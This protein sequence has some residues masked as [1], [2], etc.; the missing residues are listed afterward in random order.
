MLVEL[1]VAV[2][3]ASSREEPSLEALREIREAIA[4]NVD[5]RIGTRTPVPGDKGVAQSLLVEPLGIAGVM[6][7]VRIVALWL[8]RDRRRRIEIRGE[9]REDGSISYSF[10]GE[11]VS[12]DLL[13]SAISK[14]LGPS[15]EST[16]E[17][18]RRSGKPPEV[19]GRAGASNGPQ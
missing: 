13:E 3:A 18:I 16:T 17:T 10:S 5:L 15:S 6:A 11:N 2:G 8:R 19:D 4:G 7:M 9:T 1:E 14:V 12:L